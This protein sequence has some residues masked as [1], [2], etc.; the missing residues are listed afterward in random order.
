[1]IPDVKPGYMKDLLP[2]TAPAEP[3]DWESIFND[4]EKVIMPGVGSYCLPSSYQKCETMARKHV[5]SYL[6]PPGGSLAE[7]SHAC[8]LPESDFM[9][10]YA[11]GHAGRCHQ[12]CWIHLGE[13]TTCT[14]FSTTLPKNN[15]NIAITKS[16]QSKLIILVIF[17]FEQASSPACTELEM[18]VMDWL[19]KALGLPSFFLHHHPGSRGGGILQVTTP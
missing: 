7:S 14:I 1:M 17:G 13:G 8:L 12:L 4:I 11:R 2:D 9:A 18:N 19:C 16:C 10:L 3:E 15:K 6:F 5:F